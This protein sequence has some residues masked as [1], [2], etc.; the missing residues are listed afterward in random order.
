MHKEALAMNPIRRNVRWIAVLAFAFSLFLLGGC[1]TTRYNIHKTCR[2]VPSQTRVLVM[3]PDIQLFELTAGGLEEPRAD[4]TKTAKQFF[5]NALLQKM[6][7]SKDD[8][9][10]YEPPSSNFAMAH[11]YRQVVK[12]HETVGNAIILHVYSGYALLPTKKGRFEWSL[13][14]KV[15]ILRDHY[16]AEYAMFFHIRD[17][18]NSGGRTA[19]V[20]GAALLGASVPTGQQRGFASLV[21]LTTGDIVWFNYMLSEDGDMRTPEPARRTLV[22]LLRGCPL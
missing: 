16:N 12:L 9:V 11:D 19:V 21:D 7:I 6:E 5:M 8:V 17:S 1:T 10:L 3:P 14:E 18:Y 22:Y 2:A 4:W 15:R 20:I 13:G